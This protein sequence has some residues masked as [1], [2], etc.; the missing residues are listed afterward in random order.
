LECQPES[1]LK[2]KSGS[3]ELLPQF[4]PVDPPIQPRDLRHEES[5]HYGTKGKEIPNSRLELIGNCDP[6]VEHPLR[7]GARED[8]NHNEVGEGKGSFNNV[9]PTVL[10]IVTQAVVKSCP[11]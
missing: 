10:G 5:S 6:F 9:V 1:R 3:R 2:R 8:C 4:H 11:L 7:S